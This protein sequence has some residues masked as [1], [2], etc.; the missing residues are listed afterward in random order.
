M[1][2]I[3]QLAF[4]SSKIEEL[5]TAIFYSHTNSVLNLNATVVNTLKVDS[6]GC[7]WFFVNRPIQSVSEFD[8]QFSV[9]LNYYKKSASFFL[10]VFGIARI[11]TDPEELA[12]ADVAEAVKESANSNKLLLCVKIKRMNYFEKETAKQTGWFT[13]FKKAVTELLVPNDN[14]Y[15]FPEF[16]NEKNFA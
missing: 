4:I 13:K 1:H 12:F 2:T 14:Y 6:N 10:N 7:I 9:N 8:K 15:Y 5:N 11:V 3:S 16:D